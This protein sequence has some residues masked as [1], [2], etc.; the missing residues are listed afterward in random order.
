[1]SHDLT[2][3]RAF[4]LRSYDVS[5]ASRMLD[6]YTEKLGLV[7]ARAQG[8]RL[9][10]SKMK[11]SLQ[12]LT[13]TYVSLIRGKEYYRIVNSQESEDFSKVFKNKKSR[14]LVARTFNLMSRLISGQEPNKDLFEHIYKTF[15]FI[16]TKN[17][18]DSQLDNLE[19]VIDLNIL[20]LL[21]YLPEGERLKTFVTFGEL[22][23]SILDDVVSVRNEAVFAIKRSFDESQL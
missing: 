15:N 9:Q 3:T 12:P 20:H 2:I 17:L 7:S 14:M 4:V 13:H 19:V 1:M 11:Y 8:V 16:N 5:E 21:G 10:K 23:E 22:S 18:S 6:L